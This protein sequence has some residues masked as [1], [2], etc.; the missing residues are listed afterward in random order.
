MK[1]IKGIE[2]DLLRKLFI[3]GVLLLPSSAFAVL[4][5]ATS[6]VSLL[7]EPPPPVTTGPSPVAL[8]DSCSTSGVGWSASASVTTSF[9][10]VFP[11][12]GSIQAS[13]NASVSAPVL[14]RASATG[15]VDYWFSPENTGSAPFDPAMIPVL[16]EASAAANGSS[17]SLNLG[18]YASLGVAGFPLSDFT[19]QVLNG[20]GSD[21]FNESYTAWLTPGDAYKV[22]LVAGCGSTALQSG[23]SNVSC[24]VSI[25]PTFGF[26]QAAFDAMYGPDSFPL[27]EYYALA[28]SP[29]VSFQPP[30]GPGPTVPEPATMLLMGFGLAGLGFSRRHKV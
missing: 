14:A 12:V 9:G 29:N 11:T 13:A 6:R 26:D 10:G 8:S 28:F 24:T 23:T 2:M 20:P 27:D 3:I 4:V 7:C 17:G 22:S 19:L 15:F 30:P 1:I 5:D 18:A 25:D 16:F 21:S